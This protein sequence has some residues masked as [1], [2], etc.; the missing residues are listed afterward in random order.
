MPRVVL[1]AKNAF[2]WLDQ[3]SNRYGREIRTLDQVPD[4]ELDLLASWGISGL[5]LIGLWE[6]SKASK[7]IKQR[8]GNPDAVASAYSLYDYVIADDLGGEAAMQNLR[9]RGWQRGIRMAS[10]MV[11]NHVGIDGRWVMQHPDWFLSL[12]YSPYPGYTFSGPDLSSDSRVGV[13][14]EDHYYDK[15]DAAVVFKRI[16]RWTGS[17]QYIYHGN[18]GTAMPWNDTAQLNYLNPDLREAVIQTILHV[19]RQFPIIRFDAAM[20]LAKRHV[21]RLWFPLPGGS[22]WGASI[23]SRAE[24]A[25]SQEAFDAAIPQEFWREVVDR[26]AVEAPDTL[27]LAEAFWMMEGYFVRSLGMH[28]VYNSAFMNMLRD[29][30]NAEYR[31]IIKNTLEFEPEIL[32][33]FVNFLSNPDEKTSL[34]QFGKGDKYFGAMTLCATLPGLPMLGHGQV[35]GYAERYGM[36]YRRAYYDETPDQGLIEH[37]YGQVFPLLK[38]RHIFAEVEHFVLYDCHTPEGPVNEDIFAYSNRLGNERSLIIYHNKHAHTRGWI[39][40]SV[41]QPVKTGDGREMRQRSLGEGLGL[42]GDA[43]IWSIFRDSVTGLEYLRHNRE[44]FEQGLYLELG[45]YQRHAFLD[46]R[47]VLDHRGE[48][49]RL[50]AL[51]DGRGVPSLEDAR[52]EL[53]LEPIHTPFRQLVN[54][55][56]FGKLIAA[57]GKKLDPVL[58]GEVHQ[59]I[60]NLYRGIDAYTGAKTIKLVAGKTTD[61]RLEA[62]LQQPRSPHTPLLL[63]WAFTHGLGTP[64]QSRNHLDQ[65]RLDRIVEMTLRELGDSDAGRSTSTLKA[66]V[67]QQEALGTAPTASLI[68]GWLHNVDVQHALEFNRYQGVVYL[69]REGLEGLLSGAAQLSRI[70]SSDKKAAKAWEDQAPG[71]FQTA[72]QVG[73]QVDAFLKRIRPA[74]TKAKAAK[75]TA[76][77]D[78]PVPKKVPAK[79]TQKAAKPA[80]KPKAPPKTVHDD[81]TLI[82][83]IGPKMAGALKAAGI[84][85]FAALAKAKEDKLKEALSAAKL[86]FAPSMPT[87]AKQAALLAKGDSAGFEAYTRALK[88]G[89]EV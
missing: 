52:H 75:K 36:E 67:A 82:E 47:E 87:W 53:V 55:Q 19:A 17:E 72:N 29:E 77:T 4:Q 34:E 13:F 25:M 65:W 23:P 58:Q 46:W 43:R 38:K 42:M 51:L 86:R 41:G 2:V 85:T 37:H 27:L 89:R 16:D 6:R 79:P 10:D 64:E 74:A 22:P 54:P 50:A 24:H 56:V 20:T 18:D 57:S 81:L 76:S 61:Q 8:M 84:E 80:L 71:W 5:W 69:N 88:G 30:K 49:A 39:R 35:E 78:K 73:Y 40:T 63:A 15:S 14:L 60:L 62:I 21:Q 9:Q 11:P 45:P 68:E 1:L 26:A 83:G 32:K 7:D 70:V 12:P 44:V 59:K 66:L 31:T 33:R 3:L 48:Y 28:R